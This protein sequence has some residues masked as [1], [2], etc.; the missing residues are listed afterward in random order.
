MLAGPMLGVAQQFGYR[1]AYAMGT[2]LCL[3][4]LTLL[5]IGRPPRAREAADA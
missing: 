2:A 1:L 5:L 4:G 3:A